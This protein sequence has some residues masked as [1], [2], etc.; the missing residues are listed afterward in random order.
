MKEENKRRKKNSDQEEE[1]SDH[2]YNSYVTMP[3]IQGHTHLVTP[4]FELWVCLYSTTYIHT[5]MLCFVPVD[6][7]TPEKFQWIVNSNYLDLTE[8]SI[9]LVWDSLNVR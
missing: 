3:L 6:V 8:P 7:T 2:T 5:C 4:S 9:H 1:W